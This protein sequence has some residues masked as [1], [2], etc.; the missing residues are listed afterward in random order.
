[1]MQVI[2]GGRRTGKTTKLVEFMRE[3]SECRM[4]TFSRHRVRELEAHYGDLKGR[5]IDFDSFDR[6]IYRDI[7]IDDLD[8]I[9]N[10]VF[11]KLPHMVTFTPTFCTKPQR[12]QPSIEM[13]KWKDHIDPTEFQDLFD[14]P[15]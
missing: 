8:L 14:E 15:N 6:R 1:M 7:V 11:E 3:N 10:R 9:M 12:L 13:S 2:Y 5:F 4:I